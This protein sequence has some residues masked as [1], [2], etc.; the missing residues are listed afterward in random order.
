MRL[1][2]R[3]LTALMISGG[4]AGTAVVADEIAAD[5]VN[6]SFLNFTLLNSHPD[7]D[8][9]GGAAYQVSFTADDLEFFLTTSDA[10]NVTVVSKDQLSAPELCYFRERR[11]VDVVSIPVACDGDR[12]PVDPFAMLSAGD[13]SLSIS[14]DATLCLSLEGFEV[15][16]GTW[17]AHMQSGSQRETH[18]GNFL[19]PAQESCEEPVRVTGAYAT[20]HFAVS[21]MWG[22]PGERTGWGVFDNYERPRAASVL[23]FALSGLPFRSPNSEGAGF[24]AGTRAFFFPMFEGEARCPDGVCHV[25]ERFNRIAPYAVPTICPG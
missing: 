23:Q 6:A 7:C 14:A 20:L 19:I 12:R 11:G 2:R 4:V 3:Y 22:H 21:G 16:D 25:P 18:E 13:V 8:L 15:L 1:S 17:T 9:H 5:A 10:H 24:S